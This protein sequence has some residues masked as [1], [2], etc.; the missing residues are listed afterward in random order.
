MLH[1]PVFVVQLF[2][3]FGLVASCGESE[4]DPVISPGTGIGQV[5]LGMSYQEVSDRYGEMD[6]AIVD[7]RIAIGGYPDQGLDL[8]MTSPQDFALA[9]EAVV[10]AVGA[11]TEAFGGCPRPGMAREE[12]EAALGEAALKAGPIEYYPEGVSV[13]YGTGGD[14]NTARAVGVFEPFERNPSPPEMQ[15]AGSEGGN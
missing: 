11:K 4:S 14:A 15:P 6:N 9:P 8:I 12:I 2:V 13:K 5:T 1:K 3:L 10:I 7:G